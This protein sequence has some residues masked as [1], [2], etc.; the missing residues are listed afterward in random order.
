[1]TRREQNGVGEDT[2]KPTVNIE[3]GT[4]PG[5]IKRE[6]ESIV[7]TFNNLS[8]D[9]ENQNSPEVT[10]DVEK[11][12]LTIEEG[13]SYCLPQV[14][15]EQEND[16]MRELAQQ[17]E[18]LK[19]LPELERLHRLLKL[20]KTRLNFAHLA[21]IEKLALTKPNEAEWI[22]KHTGPGSSG[23]VEL[24]EVLEHGYGVCRHLAT[25]YLWFA[26]RAGME[27]TFTM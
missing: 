11:H 7:I 26:Q 18:K 3:S 23:M 6:G 14:S 4:E 10:V 5:D 9:V 20:L 15:L 25:A 12:P 21:T 24:A 13:K 17:A 22:K 1:M 19:T 27:G 2:V 8:L 16:I